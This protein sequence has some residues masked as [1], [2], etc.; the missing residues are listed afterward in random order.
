MP[1]HECSQNSLRVISNETDRQR[2]DI[3]DKNN[4]ST[5][6]NDINNKKSEANNKTEK[7]R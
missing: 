7:N 5:M 4:S 3:S 2:P 6:Y 1:L